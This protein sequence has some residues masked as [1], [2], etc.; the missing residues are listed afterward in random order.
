[1]F[2]E[3]IESRRHSALVVDALQE[4]LRML[5]HAEHMFGAITDTLLSD[6]AVSIDVSQEDREINTGERMV[7]RMIFEH[8][9]LN[10]QQ[11]LPAS[12]GLISIVHEVERIGDYI[13][14]LVEL[15]RWADQG[16]G[17]ERYAESCRTIHAMIAPLF[18]QVREALQESEGDKARQ[19]MRQHEEL[20]ARTDAFLEEI[21][22]KG[23]SNS[24]QVVLYTLVSRYLR[25]ISAHLSNVASCV[26]NPLDR[27]SGKEAK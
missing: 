6:E 20:K 2:K 19:V 5:E 10:P 13:K 25:R 9:T 17:E 12:L 11:D 8:L 3:I 21:M 26:A 24:C 22:E 23:G 15:S 14:H 7:R 4:V 27:V 18:E 16:S 1:M